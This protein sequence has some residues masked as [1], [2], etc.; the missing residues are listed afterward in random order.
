[1]HQLRHRRTAHLTPH[2]R[3]SSGAAGTPICAL[4]PVV[5]RTYALTDAREAMRHFET[6]R[7]AGKIVVT[8]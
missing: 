7:P 1:M 4:T 3:R 6:G 8:V 5:D 2:R